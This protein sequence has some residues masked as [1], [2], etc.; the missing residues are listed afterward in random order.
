MGVAF[1][2]VFE[3]GSGG[4]SEDIN[5][6]C[7][8]RAA[9]VFDRPCKKAKVPTLYDFFSM[10]REQMVAELFDGD[11][12]EPS[13]YNESQLPEEHWHEAALGLRTVQFLLEFVQAN[14]DRIADHECVR[15]DLVVFERQLSQ[16]AAKGVRW[17]LA[18]E[19]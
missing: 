18:I 8:A 13:N 15:E 11:P 14:V 3:D 1:Y 17:H 6:K 9:N 19:T 2:P 5:G 12:G 16:A 4:C 10:S 7:L